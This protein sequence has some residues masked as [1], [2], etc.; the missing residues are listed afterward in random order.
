MQ[1]NPSPKLCE[2][3]CGEPAPIAKMTDRRYGAIKGQPQRFVY[4]HM[5]RI[6]KSTEHRRNLSVA[7]G[8]TGETTASMIHV[9][10]IRDHPK[11]GVCEECSANVGTNG[12]A[13]THYAF[14]RHPEPYTRDRADYRDL[15]PT[16]HKRFDLSA[17]GS[18][19]ERHTPRS[20]NPCQSSPC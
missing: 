20:R 7:R 15:C 13:G 6:T 19:H 8:G 17:S 9:V 18:Q 14:L 11:T 3:G 4:G 12:T 10:L 1:A 16:C 5:R 2:C